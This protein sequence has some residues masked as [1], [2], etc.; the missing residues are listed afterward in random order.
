MMA[1]TDPVNAGSPESAPAGRLMQAGGGRGRLA[2]VLRLVLAGSLVAA[3]LSPLALTDW[4]ASRP[5][6]A[7]TPAVQWVIAEID[8][9]HAAVSFPGAY[10]WLRRQTRMVQAWRF[11][12]DG[13]N[14]Q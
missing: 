5:L 3:L 10:A 13:D 2:G 6:L 1:D 7:Q 9:I 4:A 12:A 8:R 14:Q 11:N